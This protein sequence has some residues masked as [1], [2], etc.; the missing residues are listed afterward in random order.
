MLSK[1][2]WILGVAA[3]SVGCTLLVE[4]DIRGR[5]IGS[6]C[7]T[8]DDCHAGRCN[9]RVCVASCAVNADCPGSTKCFVG[10]CHPPLT[11]AML[12]VGLNTAGEGWTLTHHEGLEYARKKL[13]WVNAY[14]EEN[15]LPN[16]TDP[17]HGAIA[18]KIDIAVNQRGANVV[19]LNSFSQRDEML[20]RAKRYPN[21]KFINVLG[22]KSGGNV[23]SIGYR[24]EV[25][26]WLA[27]RVAAMKTNKRRLGFIASF[28]TPEVVRDAAAFTLGARGLQPDIKVEIQWLGFWSDYIKD[29]IFPYHG[30]F[31]DGMVYREELLTYR[32]I[33]DGADVIAHSSDTGRSVRLV[34]RLRTHPKLPWPVYSISND[35][36]NGCNELVNNSLSGAPMQTCLASPH[37]NWGPLYVKVF[38][39]AHADLLDTATNLHLGMTADENSVTGFRVNNNA[40]ID[41]TSVRGYMNDVVEQGWQHI[42][43]GPAGRPYATTGQRDRDGDGIYD[44]KQIFGEDGEKMT[45]EEQERM[46]WLP[47]GL[48]E[49]EDLDNPTSPDKPA[50][51][52]DAQRVLH[53]DKVI[54]E[55]LRPPGVTTNEAFICSK[56]L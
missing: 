14:E 12:Y 15:V 46:C 23:L 54:N 52:P 25:A 55:M 20:L 43:D 18:Q 10:E 47:E 16:P 51:V 13:P 31:G 33:E 38:K 26:W 37:A 48:V 5:G 1:R 53:P 11:V 32:L 34:E 39:D 19:V 3:F 49:K 22:N 56:N 40:G 42:Y 6:T 29:P 17:E 9:E 21:V 50:T 2:L 24:P 8:N 28:V 7:T 45:L 41:D 36:A 27:G 4:S 35:N 30:K 44:A